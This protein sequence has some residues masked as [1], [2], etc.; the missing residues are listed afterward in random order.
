MATAQ[1][2]FRSLPWTWRGDGKPVPEPPV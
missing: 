1:G 2:M